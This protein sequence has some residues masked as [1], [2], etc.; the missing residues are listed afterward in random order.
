MGSGLDPDCRAPF[1]SDLQGQQQL[2]CAQGSDG[3][4][5]GTEQARTL[6]AHLSLDPYYQ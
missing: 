3:D 2:P 4:P 6:S 1:R 5:V